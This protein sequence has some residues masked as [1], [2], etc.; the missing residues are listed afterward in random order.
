[1]DHWSM[2]RFLTSHGYHF[3]DRQGYKHVHT[4]FDGVAMDTSLWNDLRDLD[5]LLSDPLNRHVVNWLVHLLDKRSMHRS[6]N[7]H[8][9]THFSKL[10]AN[11]VR[12]TPLW[13]NL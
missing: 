3:L 1:M 8:R 7:R 11:A 2:H 5:D 9:R 13:S 12:D 6:L 4:L 10:F